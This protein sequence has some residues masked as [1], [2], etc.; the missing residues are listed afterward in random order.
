MYLYACE[1]CL[2]RLLASTDLNAIIVIQETANSNDVSRF[3]QVR[4]S[5]YNAMAQRSPA[6]GAAAR[7]TVMPAAPVTTVHNPSA[8]GMSSYA[9]TFAFDP[10]GATNLHRPHT[11]NSLP[12]TFRQSPFY[13]VISPLGGVKICEGAHRI[14][15]LAK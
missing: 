6:K 11:M 3:Y 7:S 10:L 15:I 1:I 2:G 9:T 5:I 12:L 14:L 4:Q 8:N 13:S